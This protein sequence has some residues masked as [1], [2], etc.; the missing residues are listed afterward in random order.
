MH[1]TNSLRS[2]R[3]R[4]TWIP[5]AGTVECYIFAKPLVLLHSP[6][7]QVRRMDSIGTDGC[8]S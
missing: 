3:F 7:K 1:G 8:R 4:L 5:V 2:G 6:A